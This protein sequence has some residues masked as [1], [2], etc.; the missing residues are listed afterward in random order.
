MP[1]RILRDFT[2]SYRVAQLS[3]HAERLYIRLIQKA[4]DFGRFYADAPLLR[5][6]CFPVHSDVREADIPRWL[7]ECEKAGLIVLYTSKERKHLAIVEFKQRNRIKASKFLPPSGKPDD[8]E[9]AFD[10]HDDGHMTARSGDGDGGAFGD[11]GA[12]PPPQRGQAVSEVPI[13]SVRSPKVTGKPSKPAR[14]APRPAS[15]DS[16]PLPSAVQGPVRG[17][18]PRNGQ[19]VYH[20]ETTLMPVKLDTVRFREVWKEWCAHRL[21]IKKKLTPISVKNQLMQLCKM[22]HDRAITALEH[23]I[24]NGWQGIFEPNA[25]RV[26]VQRPATSQGE[27]ALQEK[28]PKYTDADVHTPELLR[29]ALTPSEHF[30]SF[31]E[32]VNP[33]RP[34]GPK[35]PNRKQAAQG[36]D[37]AGH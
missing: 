36:G 9:P 2:D 5:S 25:N 27:G 14:A 28:P 33:T 30:P 29:E 4:D 19:V 12:A 24:A 34:G 16:A 8:W 3:A 31:E 23:S 15:G 37:D 26:N 20:P 11:G 17:K 18:A 1:N 35:D 32:L 6:L 10:G 22:G 7:A 21:E 13:S